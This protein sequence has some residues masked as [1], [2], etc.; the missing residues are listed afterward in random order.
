MVPQT[1]IPRR[2]LFIFIF[3]S[4][5]FLAQM[6]W[7]IIFHVTS[8][9]AVID[10]ME[11]A[12]AVKSE[13]VA[14]IL[15]NQ[16]EMLYD[17]AVDYMRGDSL[18]VILNDPMVSGISRTTE[19]IPIDSLSLIVQSGS[20]RI[21]LFLDRE[22]PSRVIGDNERISFIPVT[23]G[24][25][26]NPRWIKTSNIEVDRSGL[27]E[28]DEDNRRHTRMLIM[29]GSFFI[30]LILVGLWMIY[31][32][33]KKKRQAAEEQ[34]LFIH[35]ITHELKI[36]ITSVNLFLDTIRRREYDPGITRELL[37]KMKEDLHRLNGLID[38][39][40]NIRKLSEKREIVLPEIDLSSEI[41]GFS[42]RIREKVETAGGRL[43]MEIES[44]LHIRAKG[45][46]LQRVWD[47][48]V[49]N[50]IKYARADSLKIGIFLKRSGHKA[51]LEIIDNGRGIGAEL[52]DRVF[53][54]FCRGEDR[55]S[56]AV[57]GSGLGLYIAR[58]YVI[59]NNGSI[60]IGNAEGGGCRVTM[61]FDTVS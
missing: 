57:P 42:E 51:V 29:E 19:E 2:T 26:R 30:F 32:S 4:V 20:E 17:R 46:E 3:L 15:N 58:E 11:K 31:S 43:E 45:D 49:D 44:G 47:T 27:E 39:I 28:I 53:D 40:L 13:G 8:S 23:N 33:I 34:T 56:R 36:P 59:R 22:Y 1:P 7:W 41:K 5:V 55:E 18:E 52:K 37:P 16:Y 12:Y 24:I 14:G 54:K 6:T 38:N 60:E 25:L 35:S 9:R 10:D 50:S 21:L 48:L 61:R